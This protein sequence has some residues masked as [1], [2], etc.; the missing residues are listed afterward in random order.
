MILATIAVMEV[1]TPFRIVGR[2][3]DSTGGALGRHPQE[4]GTEGG[5]IHNTAV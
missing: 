4:T 3:H 1:R 2:I 5:L